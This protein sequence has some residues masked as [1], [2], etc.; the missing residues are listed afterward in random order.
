MDVKNSMFLIA[1]RDYY[2]FFKLKFVVIEL[3]EIA[4]TL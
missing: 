2:Y 4:M 3:E 1:Y